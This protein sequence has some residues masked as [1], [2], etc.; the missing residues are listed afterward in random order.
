MAVSAEALR[1]FGRSMRALAPEVVRVTA[2]RWR[3]WKG[4]SEVED[5]TSLYVACDFERTSPPGPLAA[6][7]AAARAAG[8][9]HSG[10]SLGDLVE[11]PAHATV[12][13][14]AGVGR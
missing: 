13:Y 2:T 6:V 5:G 4:T 3:L 10:A 11:S 8:I 9:A 7:Q 1:A 12:L 14:D